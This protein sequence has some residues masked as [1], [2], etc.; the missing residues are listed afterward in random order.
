MS[1]IRT[2]VHHVGNTNFQ[3]LMHLVQYIYSNYLALK[4]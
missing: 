2:E 1:I 4:R 3:V